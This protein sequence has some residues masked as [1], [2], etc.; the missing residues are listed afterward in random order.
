M[1]KKLFRGTRTIKTYE[2]VEVFTD[3]YDE[4][5]EM[6]ENDSEVKVIDERD[7]DYEISGH[8]IEIKGKK[9]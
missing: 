6:I 2:Y 5:I 8:L 1:K 4:A 3:N 7:G 9:E